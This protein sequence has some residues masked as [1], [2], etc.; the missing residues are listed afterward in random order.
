[1][2]ALPNSGHTVDELIE[3]IDSEIEKIKKEPVT[4]EELQSAKTRTKVSLLSGLKSRT[5]LLMNL[6]S[7][8]I[9]QGSWKNVFEEIDAVDKITSE[10]IRELVKKYL[11]RSNRSIARIEKKKEKEEVKK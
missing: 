2:M 1:M 9:K 3:V 5:G 10:D 7:T 4:E 11:T 6:L 8:E